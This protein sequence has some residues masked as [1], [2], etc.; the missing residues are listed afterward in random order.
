MRR[1]VRAMAL[2]VDPE[3]ARLTV[4]ATELDVTLT[5]VLRWITQGKTTRTRARALNRRFGDRL[6]DVAK[7]TGRQA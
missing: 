5:T 6:A 2:E 7:L 1:L 3:R 4:L